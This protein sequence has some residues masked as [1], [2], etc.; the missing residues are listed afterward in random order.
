MTVRQEAGRSGG[1]ARAKALS[2]RKRSEI[3]RNAALRR[4][5]KPDPG[6]GKTPRG[7][8]AVTALVALGR[9][10][11][12]GPGVDV[13]QVCLDALRFCRKDACLMRMMP[14]FLWRFRE[15]LRTFVPEGDDRRR[16]LGYLLGV[17]ARM[18]GDDL[19]AESSARLRPTSVSGV[20]ALLESQGASSYAMKRMLE[21]P[22]AEAFSWGFLLG[23][24]N[25]YFE[26]YF[27]KVRSL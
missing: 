19:M 23:P 12:V 7:R 9:P 26:T 18:S 21:A 3:A 10:S 13:A 15:R 14:V 4:W 20:E 22:D 17:A 8:E 2:R 25:G 24:T 5:R 27:E 6:F 11:T 1:L 16:L